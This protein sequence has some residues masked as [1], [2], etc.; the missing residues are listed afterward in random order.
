MSDITYNV[1]TIA[2]SDPS[3]G[4]G[5]Q[6]DLKTFAACGVYGC[7]VLTA[8]TAQ[9]TQGVAAVMPVPV[10]FV[11]R[12]L[13][14]LLDDVDIHAVKIGMLGDAAVASAVADVIR[15]YR[16][17]NVVLDPVMHATA[18]GAQLEYGALNIIR[19]ELLPL[20]TVVTPNAAEAGALLGTDAPSTI[21][22]SVAVARGIVALGARAALVTGGHVG[23][24]ATCV[25]VLATADSVRELRVARVAHGGTHGTGCALSSAIAALL[26]SGHD[27]PSAC[28]DAQRFVAGAVRASRRLRIGRGVAPVHTLGNPLSTEL[29]V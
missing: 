26:A 16:L 9:S 12:Q 23:D 19:R 24:N 17:T 8:L 21:S 7:A 3:G 15:R 25:D 6:G 2:G 13:E 11:V 29:R 1:L 22:E 27:L 18:G 14:T 10:D 28:E 5:V 20:A 4:A